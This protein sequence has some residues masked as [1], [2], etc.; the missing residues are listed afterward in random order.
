[1]CVRDIL[2]TIILAK[3]HNVREIKWLKC[4]YLYIAH[5]RQQSQNSKLTIFQERLLEV[6]KC[7]TFLW[8]QRRNNCSPAASF[9]NYV[10]TLYL[11]K[12]HLQT[13]LSIPIIKKCQILSCDTLVANERYI[14]LP[15]F[16]P[17]SPPPSPAQLGPRSPQFGGFYITHRHTH[18]V[19]LLW[20]SNQHVAKDP[21]VTIHKTNKR[22]T[23]TTSA[24]FK[25]A[26]TTNERV[27]T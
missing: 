13:F 26:I 27:H 22:R 14:S 24:G 9:A 15:S 19:G 5:L 4:I 17:T 11:L 8:V 7:Y 23:T 2:N 3:K 25:P 20:T 16:I 21:N 12:V 10:M 6:L 1:M 18:T